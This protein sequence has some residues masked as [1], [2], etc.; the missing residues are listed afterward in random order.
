[1][2]STR[3]LSSPVLVLNKAWT[4]IGTTTVKDAIV[5]ITREAARGICTE[6]FRL[7]TWEEWISDENPPQVTGFIKAAGDRLIP[8]PEAIVLTRYDQL[9]KKTLYLGGRTIFIRDE[10]TCCYCDKKKP[11]KELS[12]D[13]IIPKS[14]GGP[15]SW[16]N[17]VTACK[18]CNH[19]KAD[20]TPRE[21]GLP[22]VI[23]KPKRPKWN[24]V[25]H[26]SP[27]SRLDSWNTLMH[28][29]D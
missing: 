15:N 23:P 6:S 5:D 10:F 8:A 14:K 20:R 11:G 19:Y 29:G 3:R 28:Q 21:A 24:P 27:Q 9:H 18:K 13:H 25:G 12:I 7:L 2:E 26:I 1:M 17:C 22:P 16:E 4:A